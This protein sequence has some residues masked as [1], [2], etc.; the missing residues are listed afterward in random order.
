MPSRVSVLAAGRCEVALGE[1]RIKGKD[2]VIL[3]G[4]FTQ[5]G[6]LGRRNK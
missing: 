6:N 3:S 4:T 5:A 2:R 1:E